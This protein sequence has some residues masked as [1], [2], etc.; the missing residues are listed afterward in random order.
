MR[1]TPRKKRVLSKIAAASLLT[2]AAYGA[3]AESATAE[4]SKAV[5]H[6][7]RTQANL[8]HDMDAL[9]S[10]LEK[11]RRVGLVDIQAEQIF[12]GRLNLINRNI[13]ESLGI[14]R[15]RPLYALDTIAYDLK[16]L[17]EHDQ[18][19]RWLREN[20]QNFE[21]VFSFYF[22]YFEQECKKYR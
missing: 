16:T 20:Y 19:L 6:F 8:A 13:R 18:T 7:E 21:Q 22:R 15:I 3:S 12:A 10:F 14:C 1:N 2:L 11:A 9:Y 17:R 5:R 4:K